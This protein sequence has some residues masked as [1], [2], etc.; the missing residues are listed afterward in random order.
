MNPAPITPQDHNQ[1]VT[2]QRRTQTQTHPPPHKTGFKP[3]PL[4][5]NP[6]P[7]SPPKTQLEPAR[8]VQVGSSGGFSP[9]SLRRDKGHAML[10]ATTY[11]GVLAY[12]LISM[13]CQGTRPE[14]G[15][16]SAPPPL[17]D[18]PSNQLATPLITPLYSFTICLRAATAGCGV[19]GGT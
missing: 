17:P 2:L 13:A 7:C 19:E 5:S 4:Q 16:L 15:P 1:Q 11:F 9:C 18:H 12:C 6:C 14:P 10:N 8:Q 3:E